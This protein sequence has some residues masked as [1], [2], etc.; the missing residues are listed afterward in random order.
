MKYFSYILSVL[1]MGIACVTYAQ[2]DD[3]CKQ[4]MDKNSEKLYK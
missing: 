4:T 3:P 1:L 2:D